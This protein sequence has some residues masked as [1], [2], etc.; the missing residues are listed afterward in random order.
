MNTVVYESDIL[1][2]VLLPVYNNKEDI[3]NAINSVTQQ[4][5]NLWELIIIDDC[6]TDG[7]YEL[8]TEFLNNI[9]NDK[10][11]LLRNDK[12]KGTFVS[13][14]EG[15]LKARGKYIA[16]IDSDDILAETILSEHLKIFQDNPKILFTQSK[17]SK[18][19]SKGIYGEIT[20]MYNKKII[21]EIGFY[22]SVRFAADTEF[23]HRIIKYY[24]NNNIIK[25]DKVLYNAKHR[26]NSL[27]TSTKTGLNPEGMKIRIN[28]V[29]NFTNWH[30]QNNLYM[31]YPL[32]NRLF[33]VN[34]IMLP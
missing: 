30:K 6:S 10:I 17:Y 13:L 29:T 28:Y 34:D 2:T 31:P 11:I 12:N 1:F 27:T 16:R 9:K 4:T 8:I 7:T 32:I 14:N 23:A 25:I 5:I 21:D 20:L 15:L 3:L 19:G 18:N 24:G 22:D 33:E 26:S